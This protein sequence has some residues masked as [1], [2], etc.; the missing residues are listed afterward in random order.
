MP[1][2]RGVLRQTKPHLWLPIAIAAGG[3]IAATFRLAA[4]PPDTADVTV[5]V[6]NSIEYQRLDGFGEAAPS[7]L[8]HPGVPGALTRKLRAVGVE[9]AFRKVGINM[10]SM[11]TL[12]ESPG[13][14]ER[15][16]NDDGD[17][18]R[19]NWKG[20]DASG[21][22]AGR[23]NLVDLA[24][25]FGF[26]NYYLGAEAPNVRWGSPWLAALR[27]QDYNRFLDETA[28]QVLASVT[29]W[30]NTYG[31]ELPYYQFGNEEIT[32]NHA[33]GG[34]DGSYGSVNPVQQMV[35]LVKRAGSRL[36]AAG[37][38]KT[39]FIVGNEETEEAS[40]E[41]ASAIL[42]D[43]VARQYVAVIGYHTY[44]YDTGYSS[45]RFILSTSGTGAPDATRIRIR[46]RI[47]D[48]AQRYKMKVWQTENSNAGDPLS[49]ENF[50]A[51]A[52]HIHDEFLYANASAY[53]CMYGMWDLTSQRLHFGNGNN[54]YKGEGNAVLINNSTG[55]VDITGIG[56]AIGH[57]ARWIKPGAI[58]VEAKSGNPLVQVTAFRDSSAARVIL[59]LV[60]NSMKSVSVTVN[61]G[62]AKIDGSL[63][64]EQSTRARYWSSLPVTSPEGS[65]R[66]RVTLP[67]TS[68]T[69]I[70][71]NLAR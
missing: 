26:T 25:P 52:I 9:T 69:S 15:R 3:L 1:Q 67:E 22:D 27:N 62:G 41:L 20:F 7:T 55:K 19:I 21:L 60:N 50:R 6:D 63:T 56:Y 16:R 2:V 59:V 68:V 40:Y 4:G 13:G 48:L 12:L 28:E 18:F 10:G 24:G 51:R 36:Q 30:K 33:L 29:Y 42:A 58:R 65:D 17:P 43:G 64:A 46:N 32:G 34:P 54:F 37:F 66:F 35:D 45:T 57:Y 31:E 38:A 5:T 8:A 14:F 47:R 11:G 70:A 61:I 53:F 71:A 39:H 23:R 44:P 49:Y